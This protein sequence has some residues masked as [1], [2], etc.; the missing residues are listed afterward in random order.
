LR[1]RLL[2]RAVKIYAGVV[3]ENVKTAAVVS[4]KRNHAPHAFSVRYISLNRRADAAFGFYFFADALRPIFAFV[5]VYK[6]VT[7]RFAERFGARGA[8]TS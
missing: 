2:K 4:A 6:N 3:Y 1:L 8:D 7:A 5:V